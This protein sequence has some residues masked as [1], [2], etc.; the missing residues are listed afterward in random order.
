MSR[1][2]CPTG[3]LF[4]NGVPIQGDDHARRNAKDVVTSTGLAELG[5]S[6]GYM[7]WPRSKPHASRRSL[8]RIVGL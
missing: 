4:H 2:S 8:A 3:F 6:A 5:A 1:N 7:T